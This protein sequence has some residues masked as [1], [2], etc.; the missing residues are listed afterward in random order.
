[1]IPRDKLV[2]MVSIHAPARGATNPFSIYEHGMIRFNP[3]PRAGGDQTS[4]PVGSG[5]T[6]FQ[7]TPPRGGRRPRY[8]YRS[9]RRCFNPRPRAGG[10][11]VGLKLMH[12]LKVSIH[13]PARGATRR[14]S[15]V[16][17]WNLEFQ[18]TPPRGGRLKDLG[19]SNKELRVSIHAPARGATHA[20]MKSIETNMFQS[21]PPRGG[22]HTADTAETTA[23][24]FNPRPRAGGDMMAPTATRSADSFNPR[25]RAGG[26][27]PKPL[28][29]SAL[30][31]FQSTPPRGGRP[32]VGTFGGG[33]T[34]FNPRPRAGGDKARKTTRKPKTVS[35]HA[36]ARG[37]TVLL[38]NRATPAK[39]RVL[40]RTPT[41]RPVISARG[42][43]VFQN[44]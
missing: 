5:F 16:G 15:A 1:M 9:P 13:A 27:P 3:R 10:D 8:R 7:S 20:P 38:Q 36:P 35:I 42:M 14:W 29:R 21:T 6:K 40:T 43:A 12:T 32:T 24:C 23:A 39:S 22:R 31:S 18:S 25:P 41:L 37:A 19:D 17:V 44:P 26:D 33:R 2:V 11:R 28:H 34:C 4:R 30:P